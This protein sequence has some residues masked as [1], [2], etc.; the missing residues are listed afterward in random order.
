MGFALNRTALFWLFL[1]T[2]LPTMGCVLYTRATYTQVYTVIKKMV[3]VFLTYC[4][5]CNLMIFCEK[6]SCIMISTDILTYIKDSETL[7][8]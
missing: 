4:V 3:T 1:N 8:W 2:F 6:T 7:S 5:L